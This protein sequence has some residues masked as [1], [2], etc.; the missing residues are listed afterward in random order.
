MTICVSKEHGHTMTNTRENCRNALVTAL[1]N[2]DMFLR[3]LAV[4]EHPI[5]DTDKVI[6]LLGE[7]Q[8]VLK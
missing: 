3:D 5:V 7:V 1:R 6:E 2:C 8:G 4:V